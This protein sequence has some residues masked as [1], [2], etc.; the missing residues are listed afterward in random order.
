MRNDYSF[1][2]DGRNRIEKSGVRKDRRKKDNRPMEDDDGTR[3]GAGQK[4]R[5][6]TKNY[7]DLLYGED[8][9]E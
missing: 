1:P 2:D 3:R 6:Q 9:D 4:D 7:R 5:R 8:D